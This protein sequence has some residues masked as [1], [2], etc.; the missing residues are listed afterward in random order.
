MAVTEKNLTEAGVRVAQAGTN[1]HVWTIWWY[2]DGGNWIVDR[3]ML[4]EDKTKAYVEEYDRNGDARWGRSLG[5]NSSEPLCQA[6]WFAFREALED[7]EARKDWE[8][9]APG[10]MRELAARLYG[11]TPDDL[12]EDIA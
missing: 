9:K 7:R 2:R 12:P 8:S 11:F 3:V 1:P 5:I 6:V 10:R 4:S